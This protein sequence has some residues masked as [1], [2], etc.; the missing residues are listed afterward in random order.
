MSFV[1][2]KARPPLAGWP[3]VQSAPLL[4]P[5]AQSHLCSG[6]RGWGALGNTSLAPFVAP[7]QFVELSSSQDEKKR[8]CGSPSADFP[9]AETFPS[10]LGAAGQAPGAVRRCWPWA[11][12]CPA[13]GVLAAAACF[14]HCRA[15][16]RRRTQQR[17]VKCCGTL[18]LYTCHRNPA[19]LFTALPFLPS[20]PL[21]PEPPEHSPIGFICCC[22]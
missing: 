1:S 12:P 9:P 18:A 2:Q 20:L 22:V 21:Q 16:G 13:A 11:L 7:I 14:L 5:G 3:Q 4:L 8:H 19:S 6:C 15:R 17:Q 10:P